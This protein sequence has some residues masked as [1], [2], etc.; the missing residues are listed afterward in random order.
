[1][2]KS[3]SKP[4]AG[5]QKKPV[6]WAKIVP[7]I[8][9][10]AVLLGFAF[11]AMKPAGPKVTVVDVKG[12]QQAQSQGARVVDVRSPAEFAGGHIPGAQ[13][14]PLDSFQASASQWDKSAPIVV[15]CQT[16]SR[17]AEAVTMLQGLGFKNILHFDKG[18]VAW[19]GELQTGGT[20]SSGPSLKPTVTPVMYEFYTGW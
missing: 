13:N 7:W 17:S 2:S 16:G 14:V 20:S 4:K 12:L 6:A 3:T 10:A 5:K 18:I 1:M 19:T 11:F 9:V 15:Y 8:V